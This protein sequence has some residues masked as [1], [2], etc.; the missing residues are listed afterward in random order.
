[1]IDFQTGQ[2]FDWFVSG[3]TAFTLIER[4]PA[5]VTGSPRGATAETVYTQIID[6]VPLS[7]GTH[8][9][10]IEMTR[11]PGGD[12]V[13][14]R[15]DGR[16]VSKVHRIGIPLDVQGVPYTGVYPT[17]AQ[18]SSLGTTWVS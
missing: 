13:E 1:M 10:A 11:T 8:D 4:L 9:F 5:G 12:F 6:E 17:S 7:P 2:L 3:S 18:G 15:L 14:F 16:L